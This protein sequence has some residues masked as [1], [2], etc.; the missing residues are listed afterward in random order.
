MAVARQACPQ[1]AVNLPGNQPNPNQTLKSDPDLRGKLPKRNPADMVA[2]E[3][4]DTPPVE[5]RP[6]CTGRLSGMENCHAAPCRR[7]TA[8]GGVEKSKGCG[9][10]VQRLCPT[11]PKVLGQKSKGCQHPLLRPLFPASSRGIRDH[12]RQT[13][14]LSGTI[15]IEPKSVIRAFVYTLTV[16]PYHFPSG[17]VCRPSS[18]LSFCLAVARYVCNKPTRHLPTIKRNRL[19]IS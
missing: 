15:G 11:S 6:T 2:G 18:C 7:G 14:T 4:V 16:V 5:T 13:Q 19:G 10:Q 12:E 9:R 3:W 17:F 8:E 1:L